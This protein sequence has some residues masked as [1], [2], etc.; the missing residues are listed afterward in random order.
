MLAAENLVRKLIP[1]GLP[2]VMVDSLLEHEGPRTLTGFGIEDGN[3]FV[4]KGVFSEAGIIENMAQSAALRTGWSAMHENTADGDFKPPIG[5][6]GSV[7]NF[8]LYRLPGVNTKIETEILVEAEVFNATIIK[9]YVR[10]DAEVLAEAE[11][12]IFIN[13]ESG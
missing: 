2:M 5:V 7:K 6:I 10:A 8:K 3:L 1:Q 11:L 4:S 9:A 13:E 12:K